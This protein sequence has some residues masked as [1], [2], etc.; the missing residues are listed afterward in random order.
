LTKGGREK[1]QINKI[2][3][4]KGGIAPN[5]YEIQRIMTEYFENLYSNELEKW[6][7]F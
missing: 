5:M 4:K 1:T 7:K 6:V 2:R 3:Y